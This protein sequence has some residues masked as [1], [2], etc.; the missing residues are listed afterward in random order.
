MA[1][2]LAAFL[3]LQD[4]DHG[5]TKFAYFEP[6]ENYDHLSTLKL[7][8]ASTTVYYVKDERYFVGEPDGRV[9]QVGLC[10]RKLLL[11]W[12]R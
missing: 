2:G 5:Q 1:E 10:S 12:D 11:D 8:G 7:C 6:T 4:A 9:E 3:E